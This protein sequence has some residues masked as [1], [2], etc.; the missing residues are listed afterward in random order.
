MKKTLFILPYFGRF[1]NY[2]QL[3]LNSIKYN[4]DYNWLIFTD[5]KTEYQYPKNVQVIYTTFEELANK[6]KSKFDFDIK[7][8]FPKKLCDFKPLYGYVFSEYIKDFEYWGYCDCD[9]IFGDINKFIK[10]DDI[11]EYDKIGICGHLTLMKNKKEIN[12]FFKND[13]NFEK[14]FSNKDN[15]IYDEGFNGS[16]N[17]ILEKMNCKIYEFE[18]IAD[19][20]VKESNFVL[21]NYNRELND[22]IPEKKSV[23][24]FIWDKGKLY[25]FKKNNNNYIKEEYLY[26]HLQKRNMKV[27]NKNNEIYKIIPNSFDDIESCFFSNELNKIKKKHITFHKFMFYK[28][29]VKNKFTHSWK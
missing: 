23:N 2:F 14:I 4:K 17:N 25:R 1:P 8:D 15:Y 7:L 28:S 12:E 18:G 26:I 21:V 9:L 6:I 29:K 11:K 5:D 13:S 20:Y 16:V 3:Y 22:Y 19:I 24:F 10:L 27:N